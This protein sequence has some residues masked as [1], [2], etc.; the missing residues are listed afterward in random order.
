[1]ENDSL[2]CCEGRERFV[3]KNLRSTTSMFDK[4]LS[5]VNFYHFVGKVYFIS[6]LRKIGKKKRLVA[7][8]Y[9]PSVL[10]SARNTS[11]STEWVF[12]KFYV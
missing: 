6:A 10:T 9:S 7:S 8:S 4:H 3:L 2:S 5:L 11:V 1:M 12:M